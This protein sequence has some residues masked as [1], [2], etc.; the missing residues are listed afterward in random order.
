MLAAAHILQGSAYAAEM[1]CSAP[2]T[3]EAYQ[4]AVLRQYVTFD[5]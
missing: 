1:R 3:R 2:H 4:G 5:K